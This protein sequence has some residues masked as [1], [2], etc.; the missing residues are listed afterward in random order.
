M[1]SSRVGGSRRSGREL[2]STAVPLS[3]HAV[4]TFSASN[5]D[6]GRIPLPPVT[7]RPVQWPSTS[8]CGFSTALI[9]RRVIAG[10]SIFS[11]ECTLATTTSS[12]SS[13]SGSW[14]SEP[15]SRMSTS[16][17]VRMRIGATVSRSSSITSSCLRS[18]SGESPL[19]IV[20]RGE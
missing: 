16:M 14:S 8:A 2:I 6:S 1:F 3:L 5:F 12:R 7:S 15:S 20:S 4:N 13:S 11:F 10:A 19:A 17:P 18:R 9:I